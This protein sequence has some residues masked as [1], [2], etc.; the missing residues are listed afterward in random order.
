MG[1]G[2]DGMLY[3]A[4]GDEDLGGDPANNAQN[5]NVHWGKLL[6]IDVDGDDFA[7]DANR[8]YAIPDDN[9]FVGKAGA[10]EI[11]ALGL[12]NPWRNSF[13]RLTGD[14]YIGDVGEAG[15]GGDQLP[16]GRQRAAGPT[17]AGR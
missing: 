1:F 12:R 14:L 4:V 2:P 6:R 8:D 16:G 11:W 13:D 7:G 5:V 10:D 17:T 15:A 3:V 9:P